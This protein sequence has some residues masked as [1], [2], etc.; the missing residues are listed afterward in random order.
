MPTD[1]EI[2]EKI[3]TL[4]LIIKVLKEHEKGLDK[5]AER[6]EKT[7]SGIKVEEVDQEKITES[8]ASIKS[9]ITNIS[10]TLTRLETPKPPKLPVIQCGKWIDFKDRSINAKTVAF[11]IREEGFIINSISNGK[12]QT[13][14][15]H[16]PE[17]TFQIKEEEN[18]FLI[19]KMS[20]NEIDD[21]PLI[22]NRRLKCGL[23]I[24]IK[25]SKIQLS[26]KNWVIK[27]TFYIDPEKTKRWLSK[28]LSIPEEN[29]MEGKIT[30]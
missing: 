16:L 19:E 23:E 24:S 9:K 27:L 8:I 28:E 18:R 30:F 5:L 29:V 13:Y 11:E 21:I 3:D 14:F 25:S 10:D 22:L 1:S 4:D 2:E 7:L 26:N 6:L 12:A 17:L 20:F 15:E